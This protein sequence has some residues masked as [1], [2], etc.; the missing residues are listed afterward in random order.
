ME[1]MKTG[2][3]YDKNGKKEKEDTRMKTN[4]IPDIY[5]QACPDSRGTADRAVSEPADGQP[6]STGQGKK[7]KR[8]NAT[9]VLIAQVLALLV[10][11]SLAAALLSAACY[12]IIS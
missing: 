3:R 5:R 8:M 1:G 9:I 2:R 7:S 6:G 12:T 4:K 10:T 11:L